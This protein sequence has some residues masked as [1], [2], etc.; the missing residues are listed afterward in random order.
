MQ[1]VQHEVVGGVTDTVIYFSRLSRVD[2]ILSRPKL[3]MR[4]TRDAS[5]ILDVKGNQVTFHDAPKTAAVMPLGVKNLGGIGQTPLYHGGGLLPSRL[6]CSTWVL[7]PTIFGRQGKW[8]R[9]TL[10]HEEVLK[11]K[12]VGCE[13]IL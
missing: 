2:T 9:R 1:L 7:T 10:S 3:A 4:A 8:G 12:D 6:N 5:T 11:A 13:D